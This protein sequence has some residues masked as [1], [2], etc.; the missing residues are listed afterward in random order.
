MNVTKLRFVSLLML[1]SL[2]TFIL[3]VLIPSVAVF[4]ASIEVNTLDDEY[5]NDLAQCAL[6]EAIIA[7][8]TDAAYGGC[9][10]GSGTDTITFSVTGDLIISNSLPPITAPLTIDGS[11]TSFFRVGAA[12]SGNVQ[13]SLLEIQSGVTATVNNL[14]FRYGYST[15]GGAIYNRGTLALN[16]VV[17]SDNYSGVEGGAVYNASSASLTISGGI[18]EDNQSTNGGAIFNDGT[19]VIT[20]ASFTD[21]TASGGE[22]GGAIYTL[23]PVTISNSAFSDNTAD[24][25]GAINTS[26]GSVTVINSTFYNNQSSG[27]GG[28]LV[29][30]QG[31]FN[32]Y[33]VT[34]V[35]NHAGSSGGAVRT[36][37][38]ASAFLY[39]TLIANNTSGS[40]GANCSYGGTFYDSGHNL[41]T[42]SS[43]GFSVANGSQVIAD[44][45]LG[46]FGSWG[47]PTNTIS[48]QADSPAIDAGDNALI[49]SGVTTDQRG[50]GYDRIV[51]IAVDIGAFEEQ[52]A[53]ATETYTPTATFTPTETPTPSYTPT[54]SETP[55]PSHTPTYSD[56]PT[57]TATFTETFTPSFT[58]TS[59]ETPT[60]TYTASETYTATYTETLT[61]THTSTET[62]TATFTATYTET[63]TFTPTHTETASATFTSTPSATFTS[64][65]TATFTPA[66]TATSTNTFTPTETAVAA[67]FTSTFTASPTATETMLVDVTSTFTPTS[68]ATMPEA[69][70]TSMA[71]GTYPPPPLEVP[72]SEMS[73]AE[74]SI[75]RSGIPDGLQYAIYGRTLYQNGTPTTHFGSDLY[76]AGAIGVEGIQALGILQAVDIFSPVGVTYFEGGAVFCLRGE[77][78]LIWLAASNAPRIAEIIGSYEIEE[79]PGFT[80]ATLFEPGTLVLVRENPAGVSQKIQRL[81]DVIEATD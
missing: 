54:Y 74:D 71:T 67:T 51:G 38:S 7:A 76:D 22:G 21:N 61:A 58:P 25:G 70:Q 2:C 33:N 75:V 46:S 20:N 6:R 73:M 65:E 18:Y 36:N 81:V 48:L 72:F 27:D 45:K 4:A 9:S 69:T 37:A 53:S 49:L 56:T 77:G 15:R 24:L 42:D 60:A 11:T 43:C 68:T 78:T 3:G 23:G 10:A 59:T 19:L 62:Y 1:C 29:A 28:A 55:T 16:N 32:L 50:S 63:S 40:S 13:P 5:E 8:N 66:I 80:C 52:T 41:A 30:P 79:F 64:T 57:Y 44:A 31:S 39:N 34:L 26:G 47:G 12:S 35:G 17:F 14:H